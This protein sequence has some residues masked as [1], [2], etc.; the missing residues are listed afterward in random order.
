MK[1]NYWGKLAVL[2][3]VLA[4]APAAFAQLNSNQAQ[5]QL[6]ATLGESV[7]VSA[8]PGTVNFALPAAGVANGSAPV[9]VTTSWV[10]AGGRTAVNLYAYF[11][12]AVALT[13]GT[14]NIP[15]ANVS[16]SVNGGAFGAF[17]GG[18][19]PFGVNS[20]QMFTQAINNANRNSSRNDSIDLRINT[21][22][23]NLPAS[24]YTGVLNIQAQ[25]I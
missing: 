11:S 3:L 17:T 5:V 23:L 9:A 10:L 22:G 24:T 4:V 25:A 7:T 19:G 15:T 18:A 6:N 1:S 2:A 20:I 14:N 21:A 13:D 12:S 8:A 16:G